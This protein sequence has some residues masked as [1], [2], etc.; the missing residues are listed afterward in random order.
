M[1]KIEKLSRIIPNIGLP[2]ALMHPQTYMGPYTNKYN[3][4][5]PGGAGKGEVGSYGLADVDFHLE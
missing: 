2:H 4:S 5:A 3:I 1:G